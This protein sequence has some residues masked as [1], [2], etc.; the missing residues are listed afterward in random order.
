M[1]EQITHKNDKAGNLEYHR[2]WWVV[3][4]LLHILVSFATYEMYS[5][6]VVVVDVVIWW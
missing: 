6:V 1:Y 4:L 2:R 5:K 3:Q